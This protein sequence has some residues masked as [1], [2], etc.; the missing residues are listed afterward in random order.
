MKIHKVWLYFTQYA[1]VDVE[2]VTLDTAT[3]IAWAWDKAGFPLG[4][5]L[6]NKFPQIKDWGR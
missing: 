6:A 1:W 2:A 4:E 3:Q 5:E